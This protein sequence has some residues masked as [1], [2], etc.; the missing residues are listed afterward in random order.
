MVEAPFGFFEVVIEVLPANAAKFCQAQFGVAPERLDAVDVT[1]G[2]GKF[3][4]VMMDAM[5]LIAFHHQTVLGAPAIGVDRALA[6]KHLAAN[7]CDQFS[8][9]AVRWLLR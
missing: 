3:I 6:R 4:L 5:V 2:S 9:R 7:H 8:L 1:T